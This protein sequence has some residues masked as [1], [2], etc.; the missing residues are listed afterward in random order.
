MAHLPLYVDA[1]FIQTKLANLMSYLFVRNDY[2][3]YEYF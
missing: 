2:S 3:I 1:Y